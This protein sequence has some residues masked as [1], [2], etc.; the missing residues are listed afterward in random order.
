MPAMAGAPWRK[1][2]DVQPAASTSKAAEMARAAAGRRRHRL[3][4]W[5]GELY[6][7]RMLFENIEDDP[8][9]ETRFFVIGREAARRSGDDKT[10]IMF[11]TAHK[12]G[13]W[14]RCW[15]SSRRTAS[16][17]PTSKNARARR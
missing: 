17:S 16:T 1:D 5:P 3:R 7:L 11:T 12:P 9:N 4:R 14:P 10:A 15:T 6:G 8:D 13:R 2:R